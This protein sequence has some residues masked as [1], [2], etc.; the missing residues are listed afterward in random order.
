[1][2]HSIKNL[3]FQQG[4]FT[5]IIEYV[6]QKPYILL[7]NEYLAINRMLSY[8]TFCSKEIFEYLSIKLPDGTYANTVRS[9]FAQVNKS[10]EILSKLEKNK[11][12]EDFIFKM[13]SF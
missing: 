1:M 5:K 10:S 7:S 8:I 9:A 2:M 11:Y 4:H 13:N 12:G 6:N 3:N